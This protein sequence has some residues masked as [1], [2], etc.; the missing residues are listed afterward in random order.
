[1]S[2]ILYVS[3][4]GCKNIAIDEIVEKLNVV[5]QVHRTFNCVE[6]KGKLV[7]EAGF[8]IKTFNVES[9]SYKEKVWNPLEKLLGLNCGFVRKEGEYMGCIL[10]WPNAFRPSACQEC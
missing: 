3:S 10:N 6:A 9:M 4:E 5:C 1:M 7:R 2:I 8:C